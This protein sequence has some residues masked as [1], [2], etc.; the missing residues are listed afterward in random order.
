MEGWDR[1]T[2]FVVLFPVYLR[3]INLLKIMSVVRSA[4]CRQFP[5]GAIGYGWRRALIPSHPSLCGWGLLTPPA[6]TTA[7][8]LSLPLPNSDTVLVQTPLQLPDPTFSSQRQKVWKRNQSRIQTPAPA[9]KR[10]RGGNKNQCGT[11]HLCMSLPHPGVLRVF[12][13]Q[14]EVVSDQACVQEQPLRNS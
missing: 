9:D 10:G 5:A 4:T 8:R 2:C 11:Q 12:W 13:A 6:T 1:C 7:L 14:K 3:R